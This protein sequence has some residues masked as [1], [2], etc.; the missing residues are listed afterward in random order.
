MFLSETGLVRL[1]LSRP[2]AKLRPGRRQELKPDTT[3]MQKELPAFAP[4]A[5]W[6]AVFR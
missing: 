3:P 4:G 5:A 1:A 2:R 6:T